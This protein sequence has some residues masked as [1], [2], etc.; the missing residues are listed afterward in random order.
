VPIIHT[1]GLLVE[2]VTH[3]TTPHTLSYV[4]CGC[5]LSARVSKASNNERNGSANEKFD[6]ILLRHTACYQHYTLPPL[7][8]EPGC[9]C[10][11]KRA[12]RD[13]WFV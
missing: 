7:P 11:S 9:E 8:L 10:R 5:E 6:S 2:V 13:K 12:K 3:Q 1:E 4:V